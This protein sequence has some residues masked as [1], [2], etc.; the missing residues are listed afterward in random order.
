MA[1][2]RLDTDQ[3]FERLLTNHQ[4]LRLPLVRAGDRLSVGVDED[5]WRRW[6]VEAE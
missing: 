4:L 5:G 2:L 6:L 1:Y 3:L